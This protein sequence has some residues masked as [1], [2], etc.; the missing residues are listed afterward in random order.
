MFSFDGNIDCLN[1]QTV[2]PSEFTLPEYSLPDQS[3]NEQMFVMDV[4]ALAN[5]K[6]KAKLFLQQRFEEKSFPTFKEFRSYFPLTPRSTYYMWKRALH[7]GVP[8]I[9]G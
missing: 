1:G 4:V 8:L 3:S 5:F 9:H 2:S 6:A 7:H